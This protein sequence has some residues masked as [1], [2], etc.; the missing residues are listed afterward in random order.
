MVLWA[1]CEQWEL[2]C[3]N[4]GCSKV[5]ALILKKQRHWEWNLAYELAKYTEEYIGN[6]WIGKYTYSHVKLKINS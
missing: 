1:S 3:A 4:N 5:L 2:H 6:W